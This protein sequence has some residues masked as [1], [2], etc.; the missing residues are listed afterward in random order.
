MAL[1]I[2]SLSI[3][4]QLTAACLAWRFMIATNRQWA[5][6][7]IATALTLMGVRRAIALFHLLETGAITSISISA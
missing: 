7:L 5:W 6:G 1:G 4:I 2:L 3:L